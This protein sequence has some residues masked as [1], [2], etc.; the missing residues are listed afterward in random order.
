MIT[1]SE[2]NF[3][4]KN[5]YIVKKN[6]I[7]KKE[8]FKINSIVNSIISKEKER[9]KKISNNGG[10]QKY[11]N[12]HFVYN[13]NSTK[14]KEI[15]RLNNPQN[16]HKIFFKLSRHKK[17]I[18]IVKKLIGGT[19]RFH[20]GK[21]NFKLPNKKKGSEVEWHQDWAFYPH[22]N[23]DLITVGIYLENCTEENG[24][25]KVL[26]KSHKMP[27]YSHH[28]MKDFIGRI[29]VKKE[30]INTKKNVSLAGEAGTVT[31]HHCRMIHGSGLNQKNNN[32]PLILFGYRACDAWPI[33]NDGNPHHDVNF[34]NYNK[35]IIFGK[36]TLTPRF[37]NVPVIIPLPKR[38][39]YVS[40]YQLQ[41]NK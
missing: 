8:I 1:K 17:I 19:V 9:Q 31:F 14:N 27:V 30:K 7:S 21:L 37:K 32:R 15:L 24:P 22:T 2:I 13:T 41:R 33:V 16:N 12:S 10:T 40:I 4:K 26:P 36:K 11:N 25:L 34:K 39:H 20:L 23:D 35:N 38:E 29:D 6:L 3:Y 28:G 18:S 5:G